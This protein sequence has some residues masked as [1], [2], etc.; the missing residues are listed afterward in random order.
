MITALHSFGARIK[1]NSYPP[2]PC[3]MIDSIGKW[4]WGKL[5]GVCPNSLKEMAKA[6]SHSLDRAVSHHPWNVEVLLQK[7]G[8]NM[9]MA[10]RRCCCLMGTH[11]Q[12][13]ESNASL[14]VSADAIGRHGDGAFFSF[15]C[16]CGM[17]VWAQPGRH[18]MKYLNEVCGCCK[19]KDIFL[20]LAQKLLILDRIHTILYE[21]INLSPCLTSNVFPLHV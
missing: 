21:L 17:C 15:L 18:K 14:A 5:E 16:W 11:L 13:S 6:P 3:L 4:W 7:K 12:N 8:R 10:L 2:R 19:W 9:A 1:R 20:D